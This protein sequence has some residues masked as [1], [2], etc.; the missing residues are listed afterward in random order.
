[1]KIYEGIQQM[2]QVSFDATAKPGDASQLAESLAGSMG[3]LAPEDVLV[4]GSLVLDLKPQYN[5]PHIVE[6]SISSSTI[7]SDRFSRYK[8][9]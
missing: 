4:G 1:M 5:N 7:L 8:E 3:E 9:S 6:T 2:S